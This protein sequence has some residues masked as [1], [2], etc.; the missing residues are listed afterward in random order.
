MVLLLHRN[1]S[2]KELKMK[3]LNELNVAHLRQ[4]AKREKVSGW[5]TMTK[6]DLIKALTPKA[7]LADEAI[8]GVKSLNI[9]FSTNEVTLKM[10]CEIT[11][12]TPKNARKMLRKTFGA[13]HRRWVFDNEEAKRIANL[14]IA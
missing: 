1:K 4:L 14:L 7:S 2:M 3:N 11:H 10:I 6:A 13:Q 9:N 8:E 5:W 12:T